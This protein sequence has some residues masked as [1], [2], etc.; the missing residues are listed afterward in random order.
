MHMSSAGEPVA[1][2]APP[3]T[4]LFVRDLHRAYVQKV[5]KATDTFEY[6]VTEHLRMSGVYWGVMAM[7]VMAAGEDMPRAELVEWVLSCFNADDGG[8]G[9]S[10]GHDSHL[11]YTLSAVQLLA[12]FDALDRLDRDAVVAFVAARQNPTG[13][14]LGDW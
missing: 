6:C 3:P 14:C 12:I 9:G 7:E 5:G 13:A 4:S 2:A 8:F 11:L 10:V 1:A